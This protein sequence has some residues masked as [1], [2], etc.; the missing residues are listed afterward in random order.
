MNHS[1]QTNHKNQSLDKKNRHS[2]R[3]EEKQISEKKT[4]FIS[5]PL[6]ERLISTG[7]FITLRSIQNDNIDPVI[8]SISP[9]F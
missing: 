3:S 2:E 9:S 5:T 7:F 6:N 1:N 4:I 8:L